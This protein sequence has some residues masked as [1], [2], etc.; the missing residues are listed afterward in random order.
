MSK[1]W[2]NFILSYEPLLI[3]GRRDNLKTFLRLVQYCIALVFEIGY[4]EIAK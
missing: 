1:M 4:N 3:Q 2:I